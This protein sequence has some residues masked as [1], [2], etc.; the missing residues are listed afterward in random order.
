MGPMPGGSLP[1]LDW[2]HAFTVW[3]FAPVTAC[4]V[5]IALALYVAGAVRVRGWSPLRTASFVAG[6]AVIVAAVM[7]SPAVYGNGGLF[8]VHM[9]QHLML[10][11]AAPWLLCLGHPTTLLLR[12][13][14]GRAHRLV[15]A[16]R[17][18]RVAVV[19]GSPLV[20]LGVYAAVL[21]G[22][23]LTSFMD[24]MMGS[25]ALM[26]LEHVLYLGG[27]YLYLAPLLAA[28]SPVRP[29]P[30]PLRLFLLFLGMTADTMVGV[31]LL[32]A[33]RTPFPV[34]A[35]L[36]PAWGPGP[37]A[38]VH[39]GGTVMWL[40]GDGLMFAM[41]L[42]LGA[43]WLTDRAPEAARAGGLL[44]GVRRAAL[45]GTGAEAAGDDGG[46]QARERL[47]ASADVDDDDAAREAY[48]ALL[49][50]LNGPGSR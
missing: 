42:V 41:M 48:N 38:D 39:G 30:Y 25:P 2:V 40:G 6:L 3:R 36:Q 1:P 27:G 28:D 12:A 22:V 26:A 16:V 19:V 10:I 15:C 46:A 14:S 23:H 11:M 13:T 5:L 32:Q 4:L 37:L 29:L 8:W 17:A 21:F 49:A 47:R 35:Q 7:G 33:T 20:G 50:R 31:I 45:A 9:I 24:V 34:Y 43:I 18:S 44:E